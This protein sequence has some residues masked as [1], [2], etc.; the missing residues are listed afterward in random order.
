MLSDNFHDVVYFPHPSSVVS[1]YP[2]LSSFLWPSNSPYIHPSS[3][4]L[5]P[6]HTFHICKYA[7]IT[8]IGPWEG[9]N[10]SHGPSYVHRA[11]ST[12]CGITSCK[13]TCKW[14]QML[15]MN[16]QR[17]CNLHTE[18]VILAKWRGLSHGGA[19]SLTV[20]HGVMRVVWDK[21]VCMC[22]C[23]CVRP[24]RI[25]M[26]YAVI[27]HGCICRG[28]A[29]WFVWRQQGGCGCLSF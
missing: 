17:S 1:L 27:I 26:N 11:V 25:K 18:P 9:S 20:E 3:L 14:K 24:L 28:D 10:I 21:G 15:W 23:V 7:Y 2:I 6:P 22:V 8:V 16:E 29:V 12:G 13:L 4:Y 19:D 5:L